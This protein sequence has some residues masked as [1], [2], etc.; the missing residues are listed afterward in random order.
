M[1]VTAA[2]SVAIYYFAMSRRLPEETVRQRL[3][4][5]S[6]ELEKEDGAPAPV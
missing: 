1:V 4:S 3:V 6:D 2:F 5:G